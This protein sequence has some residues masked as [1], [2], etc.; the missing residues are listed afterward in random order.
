[1]LCEVSCASQEPV[2]FI[3]LMRL[4]S[5]RH[6]YV[7][8]NSVLAFTYGDGVMIACDTLGANFSRESVASLPSCF[9]FE[10]SVHELVIVVSNDDP[11]LDLILEWLSRN[12]PPLGACCCRRGGE[13]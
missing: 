9:L 6:P 8:G 12:G 13:C 1:M 7:T 11:K 10:R 3:V 5:Y 2:D 4:Q